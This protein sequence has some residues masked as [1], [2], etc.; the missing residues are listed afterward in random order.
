MVIKMD[1]FI[2]NILGEKIKIISLPFDAAAPKLGNGADGK[3]VILRPGCSEDFAL[4][5]LGI[6]PYSAAVSAAALL[7][8]G[9]GLPLDELAFET[10]I[11][12]LNVFHTGADLYTVKIQKCKQLCTKEAEIKGCFVR[13]TDVICHGFYRVFAAERIEDFDAEILK[14]YMHLGD[15]CPDGAILMA[16]QDGKM[17]V[18]GYSAKGSGLPGRLISHAAAALA[19]KGFGTEFAPLGSYSAEG[20][21][22]LM[23]FSSVTV[24]LNAILR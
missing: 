3:T 11:G 18:Q 4:E 20:I 22:I 9:R 13:Y 8:C 19:A 10:E 16:E 24:S 12:V 17:K 2:I 15:G 21:S 5:C 6:D 7:I 1:S 14:L 23:G